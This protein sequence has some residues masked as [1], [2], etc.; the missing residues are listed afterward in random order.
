MG[1]LG[2]LKGSSEPRLV[3]RSQSHDEALQKIWV[4]V[5]VDYCGVNITCEDAEEKQFPQVTFRPNDLL[6]LTGL[7]Y[8]RCVEK[9]KT[10]CSATWGLAKTIEHLK[11]TEGEW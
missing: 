3:T 10:G 5:G 9:E 2:W 6:K 11:D 7:V 4:D 1:R 8:K